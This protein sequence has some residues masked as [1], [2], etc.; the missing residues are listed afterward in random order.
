MKVVTESQNIRTRDCCQ[1]ASNIQ[2]NK[3]DTFFF[4]WKKKGVRVVVFYRGFI[5]GWWPLDLVS[6]DR[7]RWTRQTWDRHLIIYHR[8]W[9][10]CLGSWRGPLLWFPAG[11]RLWGKRFWT[12]NWSQFDWKKEGEL[13]WRENNETL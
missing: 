5:L 7:W 9:E 1:K 11:R 13:M 6:R 2:S 3:F 12:D 4:D 10:W 8:G